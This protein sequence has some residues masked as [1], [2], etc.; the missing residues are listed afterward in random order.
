MHDMLAPE[1]R[2]QFGGGQAAT[3]RH[4][5]A[6]APR[7]CRGRR[8][9]RPPPRP[10]RRRRPRA[11]S[12]LT[13]TKPHRRLRRRGAPAQQ[14]A[15]PRGQQRLDAIGQALIDDDRPPAP[16]ARKAASPPPSPLYRAARST[17]NP[18]PA[19]V[20]AISGTI[21]PVGIDDEADQLRLRPHLAGD[22][23]APTPRHLV[24]GGAG[25]RAV[26]R[27]CA[28]LKRP[29]L[30][31]GGGAGGGGFVREPMRARRHD[32]GV[33]LSSV[34]LA[35]PCRRSRSARR[36]ARSARSSSVF[37]PFS[38]SATSSAGVMPSI[39]AISSRNAQFL[40]PR[41]ELL[42]LRSR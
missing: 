33:G 42:V 41:L 14:I 3:L 5:A 21:A 24:R 1:G 2:A 28:M 19:S 16:P 31:R 36:P 38:P 39:A 17:T 30:R 26:R 12:C 22:D 20:P 15:T 32:D 10:A 29:S 37:T 35:R 13:L 9:R 4:V 7:A 8:R 34:E 6:P 23:A 11:S 25:P 27:E 40:A 18:A